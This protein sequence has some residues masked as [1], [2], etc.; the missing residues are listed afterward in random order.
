[1]SATTQFT[2]QMQDRPGALG[3]VCRAIAD[4]GINIV[5]FQSYPESKGKSTVRLV[6]DN[7]PNAKMVLENERL[8]FTEEEVVQVRVPNRV[9]ALAITALR[10]GDANINIEYGYCGLDP[11]KNTP[12]LILGVDEVGKT[13]KLLDQA[14]AAAA[15]GTT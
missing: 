8:A 4:R 13:A 2:I 5:A 7:P 6:T 9:G 12:L 11:S 3:K 14:I 10:L 15:V 1:M